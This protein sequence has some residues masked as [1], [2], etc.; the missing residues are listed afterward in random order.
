[1]WVKW[2]FN[3]FFW[4]GFSGKPAVPATIL[5]SDLF[6]HINGCI[7]VLNFCFHWKHYNLLEI[8]GDF[9]IRN[10]FSTQN[11]KTFQIYIN[12]N[13]KDLHKIAPLAISRNLQSCFLCGSLGLYSVILEQE[14][15]IEDKSIYFVFDN[16]ASGQISWII[17]I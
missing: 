14:L 1:M 7:S 15:V 8:T 17:L 10:I 4:G 2:I 12:K 13:L 3:I 6:M 11:F 5:M 9:E 16:I